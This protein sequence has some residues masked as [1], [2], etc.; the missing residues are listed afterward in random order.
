[1]D[2]KT[3]S[4]KR[5]AELPGLIKSK[6]SALYCILDEGQFNPLYLQKFDEELEKFVIELQ[7]KL[8][9]YSSFWIPVDELENCVEEI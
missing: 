6:L 7:L 2:E 1:M 5:Y 4:P 9:L 8:N 3:I